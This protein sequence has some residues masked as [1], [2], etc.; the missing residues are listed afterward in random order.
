M[1]EIWKDAVGC[2]DYQVSN[3]GRVKSKARLVRC[4]D[5]MRPVAERILKNT[6]A[7]NGYAVV[8]LGKGNTKYVH[9]LVLEAFVGPCPEGKVARHFPDRNRMNCR[10]DNL[11][12][13]TEEENQA[14]RNSHGTSNR[15]E[16]NGQ[17]ILTEAQVIEIRKLWAT[18]QYMQKDLARMF[19][20]VRVAVC[21]VVNRRNWK[22]VA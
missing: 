20:I 2:F 4:Q 6:K 12:W 1:E 13:G 5:H 22:H 18:E 9:Q 8:N 14:D 19:G 10:A 15:G 7:K 3:L 21:N 17:A 16:Q 11:Q